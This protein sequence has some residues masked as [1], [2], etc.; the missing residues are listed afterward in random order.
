MQKSKSLAKFYFADEEIP[1]ICLDY[2]LLM[3]K[4]NILEVVLSIKTQET[5]DRYLWLKIFWPKHDSKPLTLLAKYSTW[6]AEL[7]WW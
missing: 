6:T 5:M 3:Q 7:V 2:F 4:I 1:K